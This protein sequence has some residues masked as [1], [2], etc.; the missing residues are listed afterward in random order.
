MNQKIYVSRFMLAPTPTGYESSQR[1]Y[2]FT[3][4]SIKL[5]CKLLSY[6]EISG[7]DFLTNQV[8]KNAKQSL[9]KTS[10][11]KK[12]EEILIFGE[13]IKGGRGIHVA[14]TLQEQNLRSKP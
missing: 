3:F 9:K 5:L 11:G 7:R 13:K 10:R 4:A 14:V 1:C 8:D 2:S 12:T 6:S